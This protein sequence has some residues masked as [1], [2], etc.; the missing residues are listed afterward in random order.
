M[1]HKSVLIR[2]GQ[3]LLPKSPATFAQLLADPATQQ[4]AQHAR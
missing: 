4:E 3:A 2:A 1:Q